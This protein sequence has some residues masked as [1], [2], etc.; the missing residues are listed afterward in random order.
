MCIADFVAGAGCLGYATAGIASL[1]AAGYREMR[2][3]NLASITFNGLAAV[4]AWVAVVGGGG[5]ILAPIVAAA[6]S[7]FTVA[8]IWVDRTNQGSVGAGSAATHP[9]PLADPAEQTPNL[10]RH[11]HDAGR[12]LA[13]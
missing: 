11:R 3:Q 1:L 13:G 5:G 4:S 8:L 2:L 9:A 12:S 10:A 7:F 6:A